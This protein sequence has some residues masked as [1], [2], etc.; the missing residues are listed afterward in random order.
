MARLNEPP[1]QAESIDLLKR[2]FVR[3]NREIA[4]ANSSQSLR[5]RN[6]ESETS[7]LLAENIGLR[8]VIIK[9]QAD[10]ESNTK[11]RQ[12]FDNVALIKK[13][14]EE[15][16][17]EFGGVLAELDDAS[18]NGAS[19]LSPPKSNRAALRSPARS[20]D[21]RNW[22][23]NLTLSEVTSTQEGRLPP[24]VEGKHYPRRTLEHDDFYELASQSNAVEDIPS[25]NLGSPPVAHLDPVSGAKSTAHVQDDVSEIGSML[26]ANLELRKKRRGSLN[27]V[28]LRRIRGTEAELQSNE[29][30]SE[31]PFRSGAKRKLSAREGEENAEDASRTAIEEFRFNRKQAQEKKDRTKVEKDAGQT[32]TKNES[33]RQPALDSRRKREQTGSERRILGPKSV[34]TDPVLSPAKA[35]QNSIEQVES[36][37]MK[38]DKPKVQ[39]V[40]ARLQEQIN[41]D[42]HPRERTRHTRVQTAAAKEPSKRSVPQAEKVDTRKENARKEPETPVGLNLFSPVSSEPSAARPESQD[43]P[44]PPDLNPSTST[45]DALDS[46]ARPAR[47]PRGAVN[48]AEP[49]LRDKMRRPGKELYDAVTG[50]RHG[51]RHS[52]VKME[53]TF[54][55]EEG[56]AAAASQTRPRTVLVK[57][58]NVTDASWKSL[59]EVLTKRNSRADASSPLQSKSGNLPESLPEDA[60]GRSSRSTAILRDLRAAT[61]PPLAKPSTATMSALVA[62]RRKAWPD[63]K[64]SGERESLADTMQKLDIYDF[65]VSSPLPED[66]TEKKETKETDAEKQ[67][68][69]ASSRPTRRHTTLESSNSSRPRLHEENGDN[70]STSTSRSARYGTGDPQL[71]NADDRSSKERSRHPKPSR[72]DA[73]LRHSVAITAKENENKDEHPNEDDIGTRLATRRRSMML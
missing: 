31:P 12:A 4:R 70:P 26:S 60:I 63:D 58:E 72:S 49:N 62:G 41:Q 45:A 59:P 30:A 51:D 28:E 46:G 36:A 22:K 52:G 3:Q 7:R 13:R 1:G 17:R 23:N 37:P 57:K 56:D 11:A 2:R 21:Q 73:N 34:N 15:K 66:G 65:R 53:G 10:A 68:R 48:Y 55:N 69:I 14:L 71:R 8:Q 40:A 9:L 50:E 42:K 33:R 29:S 27:M 47:R 67:N 24:I 5:I 35:K 43:T 25:P 19:N 39:D 61:G 6:L 44:P 16:I 38:K 18:K 54:E 32:S 20:P 64:K